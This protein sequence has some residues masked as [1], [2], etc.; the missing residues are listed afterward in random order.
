MM[1]RQE[2]VIKMLE[3]L[4]YSAIGYGEDTM[5][6][7]VCLDSFTFIIDEAIKEVNRLRYLDGRPCEVCSCHNENGCGVWEC[8]FDGKEI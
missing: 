1:S 8:M 4:K 3:T 2:E 5:V 7:G 6:D